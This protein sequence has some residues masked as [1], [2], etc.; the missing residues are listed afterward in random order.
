MRPY[1]CRVRLARGTQGSLQDGLV[2]L[3]RQ[4]Q[5]AGA[6]DSRGGGRVQAEDAGYV[7]ISLPAPNLPEMRP[8]CEVEEDRLGRAAE[9]TDRESTVRR[10]A[11][12]SRNGTCRKLTAPFF[13]PFPSPNYTSPPHLSR[14]LRLPLRFRLLHRP[15]LRRPL[16]PRRSGRARFR[17]RRIRLSA[18]PSHAQD[19]PLLGRRQRRGRRRACRRG[20]RGEVGVDVVRHAGAEEAGRC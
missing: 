1:R 2:P 16:R 20:G 15:L 10:R 17:R 5:T 8:S 9:R 14:P 4:T 19:A 11:G 6:Q 18:F 3:Q 13:F 12:R 7:Q